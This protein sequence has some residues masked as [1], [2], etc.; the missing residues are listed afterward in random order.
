MEVLH[1]ITPVDRVARKKF[2]RTTLENMN[3]GKDKE[4]ARKIIFSDTPLFQVLGNLNSHAAV[5]YIRDSPKVN[6]LPGLTPDHLIRR[7]SMSKQTSYLPVCWI[8][9]KLLSIY[10]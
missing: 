7:F 10:I 2:E 6:E 8:C 4:F 1:A 5:N 3:K 9:Y